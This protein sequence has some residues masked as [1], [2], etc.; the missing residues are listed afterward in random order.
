MLEAE[1]ILQNLLQEVR[2][3][4]ATIEALVSAVVRP[5]GTQ[6]LDTINGQIS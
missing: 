1:L 6:H 2:K 3:L 5:K 4:V